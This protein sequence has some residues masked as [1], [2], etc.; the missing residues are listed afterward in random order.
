MSR[1]I[2]LLRLDY[3]FSVIVPCLMAV[4][5]HSLNLFAHLDIIGGFACFAVTGNLLND[6][7]DSRDPDDV[8]TKERTEGFHWKEIA[9]MGLLAFLFGSTLFVRSVTQH[10]VNGI[11][12]VAIIA[13]VVLY[14]VKLKPVPIVNQVLLGVSHVVLPF[15]MIKVDAGSTP[16]MEEIDWVLL[17]TFFAYAITGQLVHEVI[18]GDAITRFS[19]RTQQAIIWASSLVTIAAG[20]W[21]TAYLRMYY[22]LPF[23]FIP[24]GTLYT[25][26]KPTTSTKG[27]KDVGIVLGNVIMFYFL[28]LILQQ[29][30]GAL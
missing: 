30:F 28:V 19:L 4:Y 20:I 15:I 1:R 10:P 3:I 16:V 29:Q 24:L 17:L 7:I 8:E 26:R 13:M 22:F 5:F 2:D 23:V 12:L 18:D 11:I 14:C 27:V 25:F 9:A 6:A 21:A